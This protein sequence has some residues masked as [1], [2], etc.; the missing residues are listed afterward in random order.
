MYAATHVCIKVWD[1]IVFHIDG[2]LV[3]NTTSRKQKDHLVITLWLV[4]PDSVFSTERISVAMC[5][6]LKLS[7]VPRDHLEIDLW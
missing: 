7:A 1:E 2:H 4:A 6:L 5:P 3:S